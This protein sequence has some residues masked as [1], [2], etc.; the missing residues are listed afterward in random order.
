MPVLDGISTAKIVELKFPQISIVMLTAFAHDDYLMKSLTASIKGFLTKDIPSSQLA[1]VLRQINAGFS[2]LSSR[3]NQVLSQNVSKKLIDDEKQQ[4]FRRDVD[5]LPDYLKAVFM[6]L[7]QAKPNK[8][9]A[10]ELNLSESTVRIYV[11]E[12]FGHM[13]FNNRGELTIAALRAGY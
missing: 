1:D 10:R 2:V 8:T 9:I 12:I 3:P 5:E 6:L 13:G 11:S 7:I 4:T